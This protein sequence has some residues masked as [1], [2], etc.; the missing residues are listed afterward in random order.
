MAEQIQTPTLFKPPMQVGNGDQSVL[1][2]TG[3]TV[4]KV[5]PGRLCRIAVVTAGAAGAAYDCPV[6]GDAAAGNKIA[7]I[8]ATLGL[9]LDLDW[10]LVTGL[11]IVPGSGQVLAVSFS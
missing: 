1:N 7:T 4:V 3:A 10:P 11:T 8:P 5:G 9:V 6:A 2:I